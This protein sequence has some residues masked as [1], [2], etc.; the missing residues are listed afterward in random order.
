MLDEYWKTQRRGQQSGVAG[1][2]PGQIKP[3]ER[4]DPLSSMNGT[5]DPYNPAEGGSLWKGIAIGLVCQLA[6]L[7]FVVNLPMS[8]VRLLGYL[9]FALVQ[10]TYLYP[11][12]VFFQK[13]KQGLTSNGIIIVGVVSLLV[14]AAWFGY[15]LLHG[16][17]PSLS[18]N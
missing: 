3:L 12:A 6:Y 11:L 5:D 17:L 7:L 8:E 15:S 4:S 18:A 14:A 13:R 1:E 16:T 10:F 2:R 9:L